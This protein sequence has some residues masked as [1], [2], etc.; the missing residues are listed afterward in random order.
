[1]KASEV[2]GD[3]W[4]VHGAS[5]GLVPAVFGAGLEGKQE[6]TGPFAQRGVREL[7]LGPESCPNEVKRKDHQL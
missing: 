6:G 1:M 5:R 2:P 4:R 3:Y 7:V